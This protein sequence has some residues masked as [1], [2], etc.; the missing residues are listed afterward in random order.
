M[1]CPRCGGGLEVRP[2]T[3]RLFKC[4]F[5]QVDVYMPDEIWRLFHPVKKVEPLYVGFAGKSLW[6]LR[7]EEMKRQEQERMLAARREAELG[8]A[9]AA[10]AR[11][12]VLRRAAAARGVAWRAV[13]VHLG[14][15]AAAVG[16]TWWHALAGISLMT[17]PIVGGIIVIG[18][19]TIVVCALVSRPI[20]IATGYPGAW[21]IFATWFWIPYAMLMPVV[22]QVMA[23]IRVI[24][25]ARG[26]FAGSTITT[27]GS[28]STYEAVRLE[29]GEGRP[30]AAFFLGLA[31]LWPMALLGV[32]DP[33][34]V[35]KIV[36]W[37][38]LS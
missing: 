1:N 18:I 35:V 12:G 33:R 36:A 6:R 26:S 9:G 14:L 15:L 29:Q 4:G 24:I 7:Q 20:G 5:C 3:D 8:R 27:N 2:A 31:L 30:A 13:L 10:H 11:E 16:V 19:A 25:L 17:A 22:G 23:L 32:A 38:G 34:L 37:L 21:L 28:S